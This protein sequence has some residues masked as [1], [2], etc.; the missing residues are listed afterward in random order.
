MNPQFSS[1]SMQSGSYNN[2]TKF[3]N[4]S[5]NTREVI[6]NFVSWYGPQLRAYPWQPGG[7][8]DHKFLPY[9][10]QSGS[11]NKCAKFHNIRTNNRGVLS[12]FVGCYGP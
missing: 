8:K 3:D 12:N 7:C 6:R 10:M 2:C 11:Y 9:V 5:S 1:D 4:I